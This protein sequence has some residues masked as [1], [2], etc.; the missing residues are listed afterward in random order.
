VRDQLLVRLTESGDAA[1]ADV[2]ADGLKGDVTTGPIE[3]VAGRARGRTVTLVV[4]GSDVL[5]TEVDL[6]LRRR[7][8]LLQAIPFA[9]EDAVAEDVEG[10][11]FAVGSRQ[12]GGAV[13]VAALSRERFDAWMQALRGQGIEPHRVVPETLALPRGADEW[14]VLVEGERALV[15]TGPESGFAVD[16][17]NLPRVVRVTL[18]EANSRRPARI[19]VSGDDPNARD[20]L[21]A[22]SA[23]LV[24]ATVADPDPAPPLA[25]LARGLAGSPGIDLLQGPYDRRASLAA[26]LR[27]WR[28]AAVL[29]ALWVVVEVGLQV[30]DYRA[31]AAEQARLAARI[32]TVFRE[33][34][35]GAQRMVNPRVQ[36]ER[37]L[38]AS[39]T[40]GGSAAGFLALLA[41]SGQVMREQ[42]GSARLTG[43]NFRSGRLDLDIEAPDVQ[44]LDQLKQAIGRRDGLQS[45][46]QTATARGG[47]VQSRIQVRRTEG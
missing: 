32:E 42:A 23:D 28:A 5:L 1:W 20:E 11:H 29:A 35:P 19:V 37:A 30:Y 10:L 45:E 2:G 43:L 3:T 17:E 25:L 40:R 6:P 4:P 24:E 7:Q 34:L 27:P 14:R 21:A 16:R 18:E 41:E 46:I 8:R 47:R 12:P 36:I 22:A 38:K 13:A 33:A 9:L 15:R 26:R 44:A 39:G 31:L